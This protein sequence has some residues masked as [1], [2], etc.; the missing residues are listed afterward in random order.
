[1]D[2]YKGEYI[3]IILISS[4]GAEGISLKCVRQVHIME[5]YWNFIR[6]DQVFGRAI[7]MESHSHPG[8]PENERNVEQYLYLSTLPK[9]DTIETLFRE[10]KNN[11]WPELYDIDDGDDIKI[12]LFEKH[13]A[14]Y[15]NLTKIIS[16]KKETKDRTI[17][18]II[19][20]IMEKKMEQTGINLLN[21]F[22][23]LKVFKICYLK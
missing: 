8:I 9:G 4:S 16:M 12:R 10:L 7:R 17:D 14:V 20:D 22:T 19:F 5:P 15:K 13:K 6:I 21:L 23:L 3:Q 11:K 2:N 1:M 18:Q